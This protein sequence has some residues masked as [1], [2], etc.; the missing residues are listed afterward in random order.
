VDRTGNQPQWPQMVAGDGGD[1]LGEERHDRWLVDVAQDEMAT[2]RQVVQLV[3]VE[4]VAP[5]QPGVE[6]ED[7]GSDAERDGQ[8]RPG[9]RPCTDAHSPGLH[10][11]DHA[12][13]A[14]LRRL[15][16]GK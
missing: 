11:S 3:T 12:R 13:G 9:H 2:G 14:A 10:L 5:A 1:R 7:S 16:L 4:P 6:Q 15:E 8:V